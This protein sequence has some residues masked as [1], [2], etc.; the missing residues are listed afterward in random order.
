MP[1]IQRHPSLLLGVWKIEETVS[2]L[3]SMLEGEGFYTSSLESF[4]TENRKKEWLATRVLLKELLGE[5]LRITYEEDGSPY[6][7]EAPDMMISISHTKGYVA[8]YCCENKRVGVDI[9][10]LSDRVVKIKNKFLSEE[11]LSCIDL[12]D[13]AKH[14]LIYWCAKETLFKLIRQTGVDFC[15]HLHIEPFPL[16]K[17]GFVQVRETKTSKAEV[18]K[19]AYI[20][21]PEFVFT[22]NL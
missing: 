16:Q 1:L 17:E 19:L 10:Y 4:R 18:F 11:E 7:S 2:E 6:L 20:I 3:L 21:T 9:E 22:Y 8:V 13:E 5:E 14:L 15:R 12:A